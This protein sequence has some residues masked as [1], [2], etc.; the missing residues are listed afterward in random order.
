MA[1]SSKPA[2]MVSSRSCTSMAVP[3]RANSC[4]SP[5]GRVTT[6]TLPMKKAACGMARCGGWTAVGVSA[7]PIASSC[8]ST[9]TNAANC[10][11]RPHPSAPDA[12][13]TVATVLPGSMLSMVNSAA[14]NAVDT[15]PQGSPAQV[16]AMHTQPLSLNQRRHRPRRI[17]DHTKPLSPHRPWPIQHVSAKP[18]ELP[19]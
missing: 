4:T 5:V 18:L 16:R 15:R 7:S 1:T 3:S 14:P 2:A 12:A 19:R 8:S 9:G 13:S 11:Q 17:L 10:L 6:S